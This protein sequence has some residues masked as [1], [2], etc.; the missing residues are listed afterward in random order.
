MMTRNLDVMMSRAGIYVICSTGGICFVEVDE[1]GKVY[2]LRLDNFAR[3]GELIP[4]RWIVSNITAIFGPL[5]RPPG[6]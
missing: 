6:G 1:Q 2:Q 3:D 4:G 5:L